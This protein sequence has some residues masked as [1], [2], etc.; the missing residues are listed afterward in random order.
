MSILFKNK[1]VIKKSKIQIISVLMLIGVLVS[2]D[3]VSKNYMIPFLLKQ[4]GLMFDV[5]GFLS[6]VY[7]WNYGISFGLFSEHY[8]YSN[9]V[10]LIL[11]SCLILYLIYLLLSVSR[12]FEVIALAMIIAGALG[13]NIDRIA[14]HAVFDFLYF[15]YAGYDFAVFNCADAFICIG[16]LVFLTHLKKNYNN[17]FRTNV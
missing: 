11:N 14:H 10:I 13:N 9:V 5:C 7:S 4:P 8:Q 12:T 3:Q 15:H 17:I 2:V 1:F 16:A 6:F